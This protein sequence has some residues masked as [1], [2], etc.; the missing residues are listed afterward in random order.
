MF[1]TVK[2]GMRI[3]ISVGPILISLCCIK[4]NFKTFQFY[5]SETF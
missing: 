4:V 1:E 2:Q 3:F 5:V